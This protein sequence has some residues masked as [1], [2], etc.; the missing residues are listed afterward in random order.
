[1]TSFQLYKGLSNIDAEFL[2]DIERYSFTKRKHAVRP[3]RAVLAAIICL[4]ALLL[5]GCGIVYALHLK[6]LKIGTEVLPIPETDSSEGQTLPEIQLTVFS[7][8]GIQGTP[9]YL[10][11]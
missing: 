6:Q 9:N 3:R 4:L 8:Q 5:A 2:A 1:M 7:L 10:A 11:N